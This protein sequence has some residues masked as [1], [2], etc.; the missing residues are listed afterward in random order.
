MKQCKIDYC[1]IAL[2]TSIYLF[3]PSIN[4]T[5]DVVAY[6]VNV[7]EGSDLFMPHHLLYNA[8]GYAVARIFGIVNTMI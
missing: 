6:A 3:F 8:F 5:G 1:I 7:R 2:L 4:P